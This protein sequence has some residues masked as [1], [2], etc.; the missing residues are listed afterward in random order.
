MLLSALIFQV[1][2]WTYLVCIAGYTL[3]GG[4]AR[5]SCVLC[6]A[7]L[8]TT[9]RPTYNNPKHILRRDPHGL[10]F[11]LYCVFGVT[12]CR[13]C[14][15]HAGLYIF[16]LSLRPFR[17]LFITYRQCPCHCRSWITTWG[18]NLPENCHTCASRTTASLPSCD[19]ATM[20]GVPCRSSLT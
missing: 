19:C 6:F 18:W 3:Q 16:M 13:Q 5:F 20:S 15:H 8:T 2:L 11:A 14:L 1:V 9:D 7:K 12:D 10:L 4:M 17:V